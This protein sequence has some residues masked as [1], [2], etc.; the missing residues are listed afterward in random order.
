MSMEDDMEAVVEVDE[1]II[2]KDTSGKTEEWV[3]KELAIE[4][5]KNLPFNELK[6]IFSFKKE[7]RCYSGVHEF[8]NNNKNIFNRNDTIQVPYSTSKYRYTLKVK[9]PESQFCVK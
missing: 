7:L 9:R 4:L 6:N 8:K 5:I 1:Y 3:A 2:D